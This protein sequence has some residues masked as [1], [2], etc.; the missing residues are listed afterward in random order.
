MS[1]SQLIKCGVP[2]GSILGPLLFIIYINDLSSVSE[3]LTTLLFADDT[4][5]THSNKDLHNLINTFNKELIE[6]IHWLNAN[7]MSLH[8]DKTNFMI[9]QP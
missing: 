5:M 9:F 8:I 1:S 4:T 7:K 6:V 2:Q 3:I